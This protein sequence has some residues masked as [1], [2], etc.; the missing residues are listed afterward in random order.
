MTLQVS[1]DLPRYVLLS[2][3]DLDRASA[4]VRTECLEWTVLSGLSKCTV[5]RAGAAGERV[6]RIAPSPARRW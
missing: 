1:T 5:E 3:T 2:A 4:W 6:S